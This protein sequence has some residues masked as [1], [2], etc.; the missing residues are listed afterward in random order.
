MFYSKFFFSSFASSRR[1][2]PFKYFT[3][4]IIVDV[5]TNE[6]MRNVQILA[7]LQHKIMKKKKKKKRKCGATQKI[8]K[9]NNDILI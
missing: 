9:A 2:V 5:T 6:M 7:R 4:R 1:C 3:S 8:R